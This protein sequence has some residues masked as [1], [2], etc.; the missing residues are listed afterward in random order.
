MNLTTH[1]CSC[2]IGY[3]DNGTMNQ[4]CTKCHDSCLACNTADLCINCTTSQNRTLN[5]TADFKGQVSAYCICIYGF[6]A[7]TN[8][9]NCS[10]CH[11]SC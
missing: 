5:S 4:M 2:S 1:I 7:P 9:E 10:P 6:Y 3:F 11:Y 8:I